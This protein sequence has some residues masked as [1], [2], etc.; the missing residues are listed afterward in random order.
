MILNINSVNIIETLVNIQVIEYFCYIT[1]ILFAKEFVE[2]KRKEK[3]QKNVLMT[4]RHIL[5]YGCE[6]WII[7][8]TNDYDN[9]GKRTEGNS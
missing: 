8:R 5:K 4:C 1:L 9:E 6:R 3:I 2:E 7:H